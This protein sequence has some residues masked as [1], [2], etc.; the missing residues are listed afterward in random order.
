MA[1]EAERRTITTMG[2]LFSVLPVRFLSKYIALH[3]AQSIAYQ[4]RRCCAALNWLA[5]GPSVESQVRASGLVRGPLMCAS[6]L[7]LGASL[8]KPPECRV[9]APS[10]ENAS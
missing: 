5:L 7:S 10:V 1:S 6:A 3:A 2:N 4:G 9:N 8:G